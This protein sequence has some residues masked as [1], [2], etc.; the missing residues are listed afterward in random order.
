MKRRLVNPVI[1]G[2]RIGA[3]MIFIVSFLVVTNL[4]GSGGTNPFL[5]SHGRFSQHR[6]VN[7][8]CIGRSGASY[9]IDLG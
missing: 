2:P 4:F 8:S 1:W 9:G 3:L 6:F 7:L 5:G